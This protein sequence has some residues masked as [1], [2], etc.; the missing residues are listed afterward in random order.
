MLTRMRATIAAASLFLTAQ[1]AIAAPVLFERSVEIESFISGPNTAGLAVSDIL[2]FKIIVD[3]G[4]DIQSNSWTND[5]VQSA[6]V[7]SGT[8]RGVFNPPFFAAIPP[9]I[10]TTARDSTVTRAFWFD[11][12]SNN[13]DSVKGTSNLQAFNN[14]LRVS[15]DTLYFYVGLF[16]DETQWTASLAPQPVP[17]PA[18][19]PLMLLT[20]GGLGVAAR[21]RKSA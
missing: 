7:S 5:D 12:D 14:A 21:R 17:L 8:F 3:N 13:N 6:T 9:E 10:F 4:G 18:G 16:D 15:D 20:L 2:T 11:T 19:L 1:A